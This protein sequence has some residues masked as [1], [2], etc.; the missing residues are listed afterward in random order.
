MSAPACTENK[1]KLL[2]VI[3]SRLGDMSKRKGEVF[4]S[5]IDTLRKG[6]LYIMGLNPGGGE[7]YLPIWDHVSNWNV[8]EFSAFTDQCWMQECW[9]SDTY[10]R[11]KE[12]SKCVGEKCMKGKDRHQ[13]VIVKIL[14][15]IFGLKRDEINS[16]F[17][18][19]AIFIRSN[20]ADS[21]KSQNGLT[22]EKAWD[23]CW[24]VHQ[25]LLGIIRPKVILCLGY[26]ESHS[27]YAYLREKLENTKNKPE[28]SPSGGFKSIEGTLPVDGGENINLLVVGVYHPSR[29]YRLKKDDEDALRKKWKERHPSHTSTSE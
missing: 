23:R 3:D 6:D 27:A 13:E 1:E 22:L 5:G 29:G 10:A 12:N 25:F 8:D 20:S 7:K 4:S 19:N 21:F 24:P 9:D 15:E 18:T 26:G 28:K 14:E 11:Q 17:A 16:V 2:S